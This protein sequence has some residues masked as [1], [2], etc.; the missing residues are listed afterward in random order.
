MWWGRD[1]CRRP[2]IARGQGARRGVVVPAAGDPG[3]RCCTASRHSGCVPHQI[4]RPRS[5][6]GQGFTTFPQRM[7]RLGGEGRCHS[8]W[9]P[10]WRERSI[11]ARHGAANRASRCDWPQ[12]C[13]D[14]AT[15]AGVCA[16]RPG[17]MMPYTSSPP[18]TQQY[19]S[20]DVIFPCREG[21]GITDLTHKQGWCGQARQATTLGHCLAPPRSRP[22]L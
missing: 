22:R 6:S 3:R 10:R 11:A 18:W 15:F 12:L 9:T 1:A 13:M 16:N 7:L 14:T 20:T 17:C 21:Q 4:H 19:N 5:P 8:S 2:G